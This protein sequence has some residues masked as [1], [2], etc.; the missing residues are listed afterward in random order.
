[1]AIDDNWSKAQAAFN[2]LYDFLHGLDNRFPLSEIMMCFSKATTELTAAH[3]L[4]NRLIGATENDR[5][6]AQ[7]PAS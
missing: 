2:Q 5:R 7:K 4:D 1:M 6:R 3:L